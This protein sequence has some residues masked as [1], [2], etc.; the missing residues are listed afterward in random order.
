MKKTPYPSE[1]QERFII[2]FPDGMRDRIAEEAKKNGRSMNA[3]IVA[4]LEQS[5]SAPISKN[6]KDLLDALKI[7]AK[8][9]GLAFSINFGEQES[10]STQFE[11]AYRRGY[12]QAV[13]EVGHAMED[14]VV[15]HAEQLYSWVEGSGM[16]WRKETSLDLMVPPP[17]LVE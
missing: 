11:G 7:E 5:F 15:T 16:V 9:T 6:G 2:R 10:I 4:R 17:P 1:T 3:E 14:K 8:N 13:A 12:H